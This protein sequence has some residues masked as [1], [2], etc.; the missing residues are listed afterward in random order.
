LPVNYLIIRI[1]VK[2]T[3]LLFLSL[4]F[5]LA[6]QPAFFPISAKQK[7]VS[8]RDT[9]R[10]V[11]FSTLAPI[12]ERNNHI[13]LYYEPEWFENKRFRESIAELPLEECLIIVKRLTELNCVALNP[14]SYVF[15]PVEIRNY[16]N[17]KDSK[18][19][20]I[21]GDENDFGNATKATI[22]GKII[23]AKNGKPL[24]GARVDID[25]LNVTASSDRNGNYKF[26]IPVGEYDIRM[27]YGGFEENNK[28]IKVGG[29]GIVDFELAEKSILLKEVVVIDKAAN[30]N[31]IRTQMSSIR[32]NAKTIKELPMFLGEKDIIK[33]VTLL[34]GVQSTGEF[35]TGFFVRGG[36][37][38]QNLILV[39][40]VPLFNSSH[41]FG[42]TSAVNPDGVNSV[43][44]LK[45]GIPAKYGER[46]SSVMDIRLASNPDTLSFKGGI[47][48]LD[49]RLNLEVPLFN[50]K[51]TLL[52]GGRTSYSDWL[53]HLLP[54][55][56]LK[57]SSADFYDL[58]ALL[59]VRF[60]PQNSLI[61]FGYFSDDK[62]AFTK[63]SPYHYDNTLASVRYSHV[64]N[65]KLYSSLLVGMSRYRNDLIDMDPLK[66]DDAYKI[67][68]SINYTNA[69]LNFT[70]QPNEKHA[71]DFGVN[72]IQYLLQ[73]GKLTPVTATSQVKPLSTNQENA[74]EMSAYISDNITFTPKISGEFGLRLTNY[75]YLGPGTTY[76]FNSNAPH[77]SEN[78][79]DTLSYGNNQ[80][81]KW[82]TS[83]E[84]RLSMRY[85]IDNLSSVKFSYNRIS[86]FINLI[87]NTAVMSPTDV[88]KMSSPNVKP[89]VCNQFALGYFRNFSQN[90]VET[91]VEV[92]YKKLDNVLEYRDGA[93]I[94]V[95]NS[96]ET[97]LLNA[98]G[99]NYG[100]ELYVKNNTG[101]LT[102]WASY[103]YSR[104]MR[105]TISPYALDQINGNN[106]Y[107]SP[108]DKPHNF[109]VMGNYHLTRRWWVSGTFSYN[110]G[111]PVTLPELKY[112][113]DGREYVYYSDRNKYRLP[114]FHRLDIAIT[115]DE[116]LRLKQKWKGSWTFSILN[117]YAQK[118]PYSVFY[119]STSQL[120]S[121][122]Y[123]TFNMYQMFIIEKPIPTLTYNFTF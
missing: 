73:P 68:S 98:S 31:L 17:K 99:Y 47:G 6:S 122:F 58:N 43:N 59:T 26:T 49:S 117:V 83:L 10:L 110:T 85:S 14:V 44:F 7:E 91:S 103:T 107:A 70:W 25:K 114:D 93:S 62:F 19:K 33:S 1:L 74:L 69:K 121:K 13:K 11:S 105:H 24:F 20:L 81:I 116:T 35:G 95:N 51:V 29:N 71:V 60:N 115:H 57:N 4:F 77:T 37:A 84:P 89:L 108:F 39:E 113:Y 76:I 118:N 53:L 40:D 65:D 102:G 66:P 120:E 100:V 96:L 78:I 48:L 106:Y 42:L 8:T 16:S 104:S 38:D 45:A 119:K 28:T 87:T 50:K 61:L 92:Y 5:F 21:I 111:K 80:V 109:V 15:T 30:L 18:G 52:V 82:Y 23:D 12:I 55:A 94:V 79:M 46:A 34:P 112:N 75:A 101:R 86:Q 97:D 67:N 27:N 90:A 36:S 54:D 2:K 56:S 3:L 41:M 9:T 22:S 32:L 88:Y 72:A 64:F 63:S 123:Q